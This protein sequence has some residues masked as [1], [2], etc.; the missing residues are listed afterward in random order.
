MIFENSPSL[1]KISGICQIDHWQ[2]ILD[3][4]RQPLL[5][6]WRDWMPY[7]TSPIVAKFPSLNR[8]AFGDFIDSSLL[9]LLR[10]PLLRTIRLVSIILLPLSHVLSHRAQRNT[11]TMCSLTSQ[12]SLWSQSSIFNYNNKLPV[13][14]WAPAALL[15]LHGAVMIADVRVTAKVSQNNHHCRCIYQLPFHQI[16]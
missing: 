16:Y 13:S 6:A 10:S 8:F 7:A 2:M 14:C 5:S 1:S 3:P 9:A 11:S 4:Y 15:L 12:S